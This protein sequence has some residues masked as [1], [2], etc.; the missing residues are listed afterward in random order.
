MLFLPPLVPYCAKVRNINIFKHF[1]NHLY[2]LY[3]LFM[4]VEQMALQKENR[5]EGIPSGRLQ[6]RYEMMFTRPR[7]SGLCQ[8]S[9]Y[10]VILIF[11]VA[12][13]ME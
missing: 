9:S 8:V 1:T 7:I 4:I 2:A 10:F 5:P 6:P 3:H 12:L 11:L 13:H